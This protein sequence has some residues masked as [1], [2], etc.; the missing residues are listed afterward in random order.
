MAAPSGIAEVVS[1]HRLLS[2]R[3]EVSS[4]SVVAEVYQDRSVLPDI[5]VVV[6]V[7]PAIVQERPT[8]TLVHVDVVNAEATACVSAAEN[9][10]VGLIL[11]RLLEKPHKGCRGLRVAGAVQDVAVAPRACLGKDIATEEVERRHR[12]TTREVMEAWVRGREGVS[13]RM[14]EV[15]N[16]FIFE[17]I[18]R[19]I[20]SDVDRGVPVLRTPGRRNL[21]RGVNVV[22]GFLMTPT[23][24]QLRIPHNFAFDE[25]VLK[26]HS[27][28]FPGGERR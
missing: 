11:L 10:D 3:G 27:V 19:V 2:E 1:G 25:S 9:I 21:K 26:S 5:V 12:G 17:Q 8:R 13:E 24:A 16:K 6:V 18:I 28:L 4:P 14:V 7:V 23:R 22:L 15:E 20:R